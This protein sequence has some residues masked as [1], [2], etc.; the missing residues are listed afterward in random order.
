[1]SANP[2]PVHRI[3][4]PLTR[5]KAAPLEAG[6]KVLLSGIIYTARDAAHRRLDALLNE[7]NPLPFPLEDACIYYAGPSPAAPG[8]IIGSVGPTTSYRMDTWAPRLLMLGLRGMIGKG[9]R[10]EEVIRA[11]KWAGAVYLGAIGGA[12]ALLSNCITASQTI[13]FE[14]LGAEAIRRLEVKDFP[15]TVI[16]DSRG[17]NLYRVGRHNYLLSLNR[18]GSDSTG[19]HETPSG[20]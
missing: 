17:E 11:M 18:A 1:M 5:K 14:D 7:G 6:D 9:E 16:I 3:T 12:G 8:K 20:G 4:L 19:P 13:A 15:A 10:S 2:R